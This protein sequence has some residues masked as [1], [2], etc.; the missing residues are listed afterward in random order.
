MKEF[1]F[2]QHDI[3]WVYVDKLIEVFY[4]YDFHFQNYPE[5]NLNWYPWNDISHKVCQMGRVFS[6]FQFTATVKKD[7]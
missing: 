4:I 5:S 2:K 6:Y 1:V 7:T 3:L